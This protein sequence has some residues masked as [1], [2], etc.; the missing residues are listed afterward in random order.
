MGKH[1]GSY[2]HLSPFSH[3]GTHAGQ[4][5]LYSA[6]VTVDANSQ[7]RTRYSLSIFFH[8]SFIPLTRDQMPFL[9]IYGGPSFHL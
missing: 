3:P 6:I 9:H 1:S 4:P 5:E 2:V 7:I 8:I